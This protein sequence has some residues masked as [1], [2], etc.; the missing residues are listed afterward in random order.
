MVNFKI[1]KVL[2]GK[3]SIVSVKFSPSS[4]PGGTMLRFP[5]KG[6]MYGSEREERSRGVI[7]E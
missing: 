3:Y 7:H 6:G 5:E 4:N 1:K 2:Q